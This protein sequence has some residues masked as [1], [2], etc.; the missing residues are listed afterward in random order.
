MTR[1]EPRGVSA[2]DDF[3]EQ[4]RAD[5]RAAMCREYEERVKQQAAA[6]FIM[7]MKASAPT[8][9]KTGLLAHAWVERARKSLEQSPIE[10]DA[11]AAAGDGGELCV[12]V[13]KGDDDGAAAALAAGSAATSELG[14]YPA[15]VLGTVGGHAAILQRLLAARA[16]VDAQ[17][18]ELHAT[19]LYVAADLGHD[20][21][22]GVLLGAGAAVDQPTAEAATPLLVACYQGRVRC[23][24]LLLAAQADAGACMVGGVSPLFLAAQQNRLA[25]VALLLEHVKAKA[26]A[27]DDDNGAGATSAEAVASAEVRTTES[28]ARPGA[29]AS[30]QID[31]PEPSI[32]EFSR[33]AEL[34]PDGPL[35]LLERRAANGATP[36]I[37]ASQEGNAEIVTMLLEA[38]AKPDVRAHAAGG[39]TA[40]FA[41]VFSGKP[42]CVA[43][44]LGGG[45]DPKL[46]CWG[47]LPLNEAR[48]RRRRECARLLN[49]AMGNASPSKT[50]MF[51]M[52]PSSRLSSTT[53]ASST[54]PPMARLSTTV[55][56][57]KV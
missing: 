55:S 56:V 6:Q 20:E 27:A 53:R 9:R 13:A 7:A 41:A 17:E 39:A 25:C 19:A 8:E 44:L 15:L 16:D 2:S 28:L 24:E 18:H 35:A 32:A 26:A 1:P 38:G 23:A 40:L 46:E 31:F 57:E 47:V 52:K 3:R 48:A 29:L 34:L 54:T 21:C 36:L 33:R 14:G 10:T 12:R 37:I 22:V 45:A 11:I 43:A 50:R 30:L 4:Q 5:F 49:E 51:K 42:R